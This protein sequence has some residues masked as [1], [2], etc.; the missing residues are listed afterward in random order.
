DG[1]P[2]GDHPHEAGGGGAVGLLVEL[3]GVRARLGERAIAVEVGGVT[4]L[5]NVALGAA[6]SRR[7]GQIAEAGPPHPTGAEAH[8]RLPPQRAREKPS[9]DG[10]GRR[11]RLVLGDG[12][13]AKLGIVGRWG[14]PRWRGGALQL[15]RRRRHWRR[16][17]RRLRQRE[18]GAV[19]LD[20]GG[21]WWLRR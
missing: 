3:S 7:G 8:Q 14:S 5:G 20:G 21:A 18:G 19:I 12:R 9:G 10:L 11:L 16:G 17:E 13:R 6:G 15:H 2:D 1:E 4:Q